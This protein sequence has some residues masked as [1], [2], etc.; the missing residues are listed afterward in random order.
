MSLSRR[1]LLAAGGAALA[2]VATRQTV[3][4]A[5]DV[6]KE[7]AARDSSPA[8]TKGR[9]HQSVMGWCFKPMPS[10]ELAKHC[11]AIGIEAIE[12]IPASDYPAVTKLGL[13][14]S[15]VG[16][17]GFQAGPLDPENH[18]MNEAKLREAIDT[19]VKFGAPSVITF[20]G[21]RKTGI[22]DRQATKNCLD[23]W[24]RV[25]PYA[26]ANDI[27]LVLEHLN[28]R[29]DT[30]PMKG[31]PGY[32]G[33]DVELCVDLVKQ[34]D[35]PRFK[36][37]FD[38]YH[39]QIMNGDIIRRI[40]EYHPLIG[41]YHTAG[42]P[43]RG[44]LNDDQEINYPAVMRAILETG[45]SQYVAQEFIPTSNDPIASLREAARVCDV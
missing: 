29:D 43:G 40:R 28:S 21:M 27:T 17:H 12:G 35:S 16:S 26:E 18:A 10:I 41:H 36:L 7:T 38:I 34:L 1:N 4:R 3:S 8:I 14:I 13:K 33:D 37:L 30:H 39:V 44:E 45:Y 25:L 2:A 9:I 24:K 6:A 5:E 23:L 15:L 11:K 32:W 42:A 31:H 22:D 20:T 19:A